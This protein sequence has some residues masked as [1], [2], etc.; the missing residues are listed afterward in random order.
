MLQKI[1][2]KKLKK[3]WRFWRLFK[4]FFLK[5]KKIKMFYRLKW[6]FD[7]KRIIWH[8]LYTL[9]GSRIKYL[10]YKKTQ[11]RFLFGVRFFKILSYF[12]LR[13]DILML[14][15]GWV[16]SRLL[17]KSLISKGDVLVN[18]KKKKS[19]FLVN[20]GDTV[21][22]IP[23]KLIKKR[24]FLLKWRRFKWNRWRQQFW[25]IGTKVPRIF[26]LFKK[27][28]VVNFLEINYKIFSCIILREP[29]TGEILLEK[30]KRMWSTKRLKK[31]YFLY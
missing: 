14:R 23:R 13:L 12:E 11:T 6:I 25:K 10:K 3:K 31:I 7:Q 24:F 16:D 20:V 4:R 5:K 29:L 17:A 27:N 19:Q 21:Q 26:W 9:Y 1:Q 30:Q 15:L 8:N 2:Q 22:K 28:L 18:G